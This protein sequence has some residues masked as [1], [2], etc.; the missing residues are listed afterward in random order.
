MIYNFE[1]ESVYCIRLN[2]SVFVSLAQR[3]SNRSAVVFLL[4]FFGCVIL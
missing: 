3:N 2:H 1:S 4:K